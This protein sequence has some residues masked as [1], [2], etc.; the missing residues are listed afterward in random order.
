M[1]TSTSTTTYVKVLPVYMDL[2][3][4][5]QFASRRVVLLRHVL[6]RM[7][8]F[9]GPSHCTLAKPAHKVPSVA[10]LLLSVSSGVPGLI[11]DSSSDATDGTLGTGFAR[12]MRNN[13]VYSS[14]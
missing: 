6:V 10:S 7:N 3:A 13:I 4:S 8:H 1:C 2:A 5:Q 9:T 14:V 12:A 11:T